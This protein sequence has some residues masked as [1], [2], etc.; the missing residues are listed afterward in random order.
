[1]ATTAAG[2]KAMM[3]TTDPSLDRSDVLDSV[4]STTEVPSGLVTADSLPLEAT[5]RRVTT[6]A[7]MIA[8]NAAATFQRRPVEALGG[9]A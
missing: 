4:L 8:T 3:S 7:V 1:M 2:I 5:G 6:A 9:R